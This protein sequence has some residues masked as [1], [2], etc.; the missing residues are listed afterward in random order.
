MDMMLDEL[1]IKPISLNMTNG[2]DKEEKK[3]AEKVM[4]DD[5]DRNYLLASTGTLVMNRLGRSRK[6]IGTTATTSASTSSS[7]GTGSSKSFVAQTGD[8]ILYL[9]NVYIAVDTRFG[10]SFFFY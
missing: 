1:N 6:S 4:I 8:R 9:G 10:K 7:G 3:K 2:A 5:F